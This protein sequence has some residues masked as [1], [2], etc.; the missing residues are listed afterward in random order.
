[1]IKIVAK[2]KTP[3]LLLWCFIGSNII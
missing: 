1:M 2:Y 3:Q